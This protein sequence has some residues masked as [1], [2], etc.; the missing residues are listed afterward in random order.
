MVWTGG[1]RGFAV[2]AYFENNRSV[3]ATQRAFR[4]RFNIPRNNAVP[5]ANTI[6]KQEDF[7]PGKLKERRRKEEEERRKK[8][9]YSSCG[10]QSPNTIPYQF[11]IYQFQ[12]NN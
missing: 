11:V 2:R 3:I 12:E 9:K 5:N 1:H 6:R 8:K 4:R 7:Q 10:F